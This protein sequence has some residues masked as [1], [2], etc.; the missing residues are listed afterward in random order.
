MKKFKL[1]SSLGV[2][3]LV[4]A[5]CVHAASEPVATESTETVD[6][7]E[8]METDEAME[9]DGTDSAMM[10]DD[11]STVTYSDTGFAPATLTV[12]V[13]TKV[14]FVNESSKGMW[15][16][17]AVHPTHEVLPAFDNKVTVAEGESYSYTFTKEGQWKY[18]N[19]VGPT[20]TGTVVVE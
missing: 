7:N 5:G 9:K 4:L 19:H 17:S 11:G 3:S 8:V 12:E 13:G 14:T 1:F 16:A 6:E 15:V 20:D 2:L 10:T 18:H